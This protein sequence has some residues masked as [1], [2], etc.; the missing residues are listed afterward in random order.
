MARDKKSGVIYGGLGPN[1]QRQ[2]LG[3]AQA[4]VAASVEKSLAGS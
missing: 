3:P 4:I 2:D 1:Q